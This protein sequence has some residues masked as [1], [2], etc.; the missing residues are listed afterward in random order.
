M[1]RALYGWCGDCG[2][3]LRVC[4]CDTANAVKSAWTVEDESQWNEQW[5]SSLIRHMQ[6]S[7]ERNLREGAA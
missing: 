4:K 3:S 2:K 1:A 6:E 5:A 7:F